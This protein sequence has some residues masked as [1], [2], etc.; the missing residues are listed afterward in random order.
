M[1]A[2]RRLTNDFARDT[3]GA[4]AILFGVSCVVLFGLIGLAVDTSRYYNYTSHMQQALDAAALAGAKL[5]P[6]DQVNDGEIESARDR[7]FLG[8]D[9]QNRRDRQW[10]ANCDDQD[11]PQQE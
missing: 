2:L 1:F 9:E 10:R 3:G 6:D 11:R 5:L 7:V 4:V 8:S